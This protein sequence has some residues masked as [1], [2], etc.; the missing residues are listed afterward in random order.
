MTNVYFDSG[1]VNKSSKDSASYYAD[2]QR[3]KKDIYL[4][5]T[6]LLTLLLTKC[7]GRYVNEKDIEEKA[8]SPQTKEQFQNDIDE[9]VKNT[10]L[11]SVH[12]EKKD[13]IYA[14]LKKMF[15]QGGA[16]NYASNLMSDGIATGAAL[17]EKSAFVQPSNQEHK[18]E[19]TVNDKGELTVVSSF[20]GSA[21]HMPEMRTGEKISCTVTTKIDL[22]SPEI[23]EHCTAEV[24]LENDSE[25]HEYFNAYSQSKLI[26]DKIKAEIRRLETLAKGRLTIGAGKKAAAIQDALASSKNV[27]ADV[28]DES[29]KLYKALNK[30]RHGPSFADFKSKLNRFKARALV[31]VTENLPDSNSDRPPKR[32]TL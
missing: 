20:N 31:N 3:D 12:E 15:D 13:A 5:G 19:W 14:Q 7:D 10:L 18:Q 11:T 17:Q 30:K 27:G 16:C 6:S 21:T 1:W 32:P 4:N 25:S 2:M 8:Q 9:L 23:H 24:S 26:E 28:K 22:K 29:S